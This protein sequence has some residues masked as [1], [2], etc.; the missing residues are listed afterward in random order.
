MVREETEYLMSLIAY[1]SHK[2]QP[3]A[4][5]LI[6]YSNN[7]ILDYQSQGFVLTLRQLYY[8]LVAK[9]IIPN[10]QKEYDRLSNVISNARR[11]GLV[12]WNAIIDRTRNIIGN[13]HEESPSSAI[14]KLA[15]TY[16]RSLWQDQAIRPEVWV[17][18][19]A[20]IG[21]I[22]RICDE[23]DVSYFSCRGYTSD[24]E[25]WQA[26]Q[27]FIRRDKRG[28]NNVI[29][30]IGDHDPSGIDMTRDIKDRLNLFTFNKGIFEVVRI[31]LNWDQIE[32]YNPPPNPA[33]ASDSR[34]KSYAEKYGS[35]SW[36]LDALEPKVVEELIRKNVMKLIEKDK[37]NEVIDKVNQE[38]KLLKKV[39]KN[40][41]KIIEN[42]N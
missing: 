18:K 28:Q 38:R 6:D 15:K 32:K 20:A 25:I 11:S 8:Q 33:K 41:D 4:L 36:E 2:F 3:T 29:L 21:V 17:E 22:E 1:E 14:S 37:W 39:A 5:A 13:K 7:I 12:D 27:R 35:E 9:D 23:L 30:H 26:S 19:D 10:K 24:S 40:W 31:A 42:L 34:F 16:L